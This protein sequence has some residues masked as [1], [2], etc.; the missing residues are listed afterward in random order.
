MAR[1]DATGRRRAT[2]GVGGQ[3]RCAAWTFDARQRRKPAKNA[4][5]SRQTR[6]TTTASTPVYNRWWFWT[7]IGA[8]AAGAAA[9]VLGF[10]LRPTAEP[11]GGNTGFN[12]QLLTGGGAL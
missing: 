5:S 10:V 8:T 9:A 1:P 12:V 4:D 3:A 11:P 2:P 7:I 6:P